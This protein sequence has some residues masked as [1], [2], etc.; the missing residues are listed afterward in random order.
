[1]FAFR[2]WITSVKL[3][4]HSVSLLVLTSGTGCRDGDISAR[5]TNTSGQQINFVRVKGAA[6][7]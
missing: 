5:P 4:L 6:D 3:L 7:T 2:W 1:L